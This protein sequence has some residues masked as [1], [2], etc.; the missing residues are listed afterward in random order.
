VALIG[1][2]VATYFIAGCG[3]SAKAIGSDAGLKNL[4][5]TSG[6]HKRTFELYVP[7]GDSAKNPLPL[8]L[9][10]H[11]ADSTALS[12]ATG[13]SLL[14]IAKQ[15]HNMILAFMQGY[16][17]TWNEGAGHTPAEQ[18]GINDVAYTETVLARIESSY[19]VDL[20]RV[21]ATGISNG[22]LLTEYLGCKLAVNLTM[23]APVEGE[24]PVTDSTGCAPSKPI[25]VYEVHGT[26]DPTIP[27]GGGHFDGVG[28]G[29]TVLSAPASAQRWA[30]LNGCSGAARKSK[31]GDVVLS[32][33]SGCRQGVSVKLASVQGGQHV[34][35]T[36]FG[37][38]LVSLIASLP[39]ARVAAKA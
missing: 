15:R 33:Y 10:Y 6:G 30:S 11:G 4:S 29:T 17:D 7:P 39:A 5:V 38:T 19:D 12:V 37:Q 13:T 26:A 2:I 27:Y 16:D 23:I 32:T 22:A 36:G 9:V 18:A 20:R 3:T 1:A 8:I 24:L 35:P 25:S 14:N 28:G 21:V 34:W 31:S